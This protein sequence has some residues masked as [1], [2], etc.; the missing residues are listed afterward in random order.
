MRR[1]SDYT[2]ISNPSPNPDKH[3]VQDIKVGRTLNI[4]NNQTKGRA[5]D[6]ISG[7]RYGMRARAR[8]MPVDCWSSSS[9]VG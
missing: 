6:I 4:R 5:F 3:D 8:T 7:A 1:I 2:T 9:E